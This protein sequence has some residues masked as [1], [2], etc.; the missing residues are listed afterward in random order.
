ML[1]KVYESIKYIIFI[2]LKKYI[3]L[4][5]C[6]TQ[7][8]KRL[9]PILFLSL[10]LVWKGSSKNWSRSRSWWG[11]VLW[12]RRLHQSTSKKGCSSFNLVLMELLMEHP[13]WS[14]SWS[15]VKKN[16]SFRKSQCRED[17]STLSLPPTEQDQFKNIINHII[18][19]MP[20]DLN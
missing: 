6:G 7:S 1:D 15:P 10:G 2:H 12:L 17:P 4:D 9:S 16:L 18:N 19:F 11:H 3:S 20:P 8:S 14:Q 13:V 5:E